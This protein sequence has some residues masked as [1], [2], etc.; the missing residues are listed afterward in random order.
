VNDELIARVLRPLLRGGEVRPLR[1]IGTRRALRLAQAA[2]GT[3]LLEP[4]VASAR[5]REARRLWPI[6]ALPELSVGEWLLL[7]ALNDLL[8]VNNPDLMSRRKRPA[9]LL[10]MAAETIRAA[11]PAGSAAEALARHATLSRVVE[12]ERG[13]TLVSWWVGQRWFIGATPP[14]R[15]LAWPA[16][17][18]VHT[19]TRRARFDE[20]AGESLW[21]PTYR[22][23]VAAW[24]SAT[25]L[26]ELVAGGLGPAGLSLALHPVGRTLVGRAL[27]RSGRLEKRLRGARKTMGN[28]SPEVPAGLAEL[29]RELEQR[30]GRAG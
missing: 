7:A 18:R 14:R 8:Q 3:F 27:E 9:R 5:V 17:R 30:V 26:T 23:T 15:L 1:P 25:P 29:V 12:L 4:D 20:M 11:G 16:L 6:D 10:A 19:R 22:D 13:D 21:A 28:A 2:E 24:L